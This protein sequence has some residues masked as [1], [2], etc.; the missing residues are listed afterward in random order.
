[1][2]FP[3]KLASKLLVCLTAIAVPLQAAWV[4]SCACSSG[5]HET[6]PTAAASP[7][8]DAA[9]GCCEVTT[10]KQSCCGEDDASQPTHCSKAAQPDRKTGCQC[11][12]GCLCVKRDDPPSPPA[13]PAGDNGRARSGL[14]FTAAHVAAAELPADIDRGNT[15]NSDSDSAFFQSGAQTCMLLCRFTL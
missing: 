6:H 2:Y 8:P 3:G 7:A 13:A 10:P 9:C 12:A 5:A 1:M 11:G 14:E 4:S 15:F